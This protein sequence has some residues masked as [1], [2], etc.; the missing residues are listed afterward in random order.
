MA[1]SAITPQNPRGSKLIAPGWHT[2]VVLFIMLA[3]SLASARS[4]GMSPIGESHG[5]VL[6]YSTVLVWEWVVVAFIWFGVRLRG[7][8]LKDLIGGNWPKWTSILRDLGIA[9]GFL[10]SCNVFGAAWPFVEGS[11]ESGGAQHISTRGH[12]GCAVLFAHRD[13][14][15]LRGNYFPR[16]SATAICSHHDECSGRAGHSGSCLRRFSWVSGAEVHVHHCC[17]W[18]SLWFAGQLAAQPPAW[19]DGPLPSGFSAWAR[20]Q[21]FCQIASCR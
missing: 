18:L 10:I 11:S 12:G 7:I 19:H 1:S 8:R 16:L 17:L 3:G 14:G 6:S 20:W 21:T 15:Y 2:V 13:G 9:V 5:H 4:H